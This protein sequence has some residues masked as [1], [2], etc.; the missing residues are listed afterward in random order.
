MGPL[1][2]SL[3]AVAGFLAGCL[4]GWD[5]VVVGFFNYAFLAGFGQDDAALGF[6]VMF[7]VAP[8]VGLV[9]GIALALW[10]ARRAA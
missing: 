3:R 2:A 8:A 9:T 4:V 6:I 1:A 7:F 5:T 10:M